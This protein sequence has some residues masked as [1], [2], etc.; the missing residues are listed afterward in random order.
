MAKGTGVIPCAFCVSG[1]PFAD[2][3]AAAGMAQL[4]Q[5]L[6][7]DLADPLAGDVELF[8]DLLQRARPAVLQPVAPL[9]KKQKSVEEIIEVTGFSERTVRETIRKYKSGGM[10][11][12][13]PK[14]RGRKVGEKRTLTPNQEEEIVR[15]ITDKNPDQ[16]KMKCALWTR[17]AVHQLIKDKYGIDMPIRTVGMY[18]QRWGFTVQRPAKQA[19]EQKPEA[20]QR[21]LKEEYPAIHTEAKKEDAE[22]FWGDETAVQNVANYA[23]GYAPKGHTPVLKTKARKMHINMISAIS[24]Q[25][26]L[27]FMFSQESMNQQKLIEF[28]ERLLKDIPCKVYIILDNLKVHHGKLVEDWIEEHKDRIRL[29]FQRPISNRTPMPL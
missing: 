28:L 21:W 19:I 2:G 5:C 9:F 20:V 15:I 17:D 24:N 18:L 25:G 8:A 16:L 29:F 23:R 11:A 22:I 13:K 6:C 10:A 26:K 27:H 14:K 1:I 3:A 12:L 4:A 7:L